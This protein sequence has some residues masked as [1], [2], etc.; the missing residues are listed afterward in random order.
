MAEPFGF[1]SFTLRFLFALI[2]VF[3]TYNPTGYSFVLWSIDV[4]QQNRALAP[5]MA[6]AGVSLLIGWVIYLKATFDA[7]GLI[8]VVLGAAFFGC[9]IWVLIDNGLLSIEENSTA[10]IY[11]VEVLLAAIL[12][13]GMSWAHLRRRWSGQQMVDDVEEE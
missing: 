5:E 12:A 7:M 9:L 11:I 6:L 1:T 13:L 10:L 8:G 4:V 3:G 2:L